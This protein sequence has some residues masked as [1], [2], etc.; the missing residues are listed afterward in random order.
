MLNYDPLGQRVIVLRPQRQIKF[1][2]GSQFHVNSDAGSELSV[3]FWPG[4][5]I[6]HG[7]MTHLHILYPWNC[8][9]RRCQNYN[10]L[11]IQQL[12]WLIIQQKFIEYWPGSVFNWGRDSKFYLTQAVPST[13]SMIEIP[14][15]IKKKIRKTE[16]DF[17]QFCTLSPHLDFPYLCLICMFIVRHQSIIMA[18]TIFCLSYWKSPELLNKQGFILCILIKCH[19]WRKKDMSDWFPSL[20]VWVLSS[21]FRILLKTDGHQPFPNWWKS[22][23]FRAEQVY[24]HK[25]A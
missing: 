1:G 21:I 6:Q 24:V 20:E 23:A 12:R 17:H 19:F 3:E 9:W 15:H 8:N 13:S 11:K 4:V 25:E 7:I 5:A 10:V 14:S 16:T 2:P 18:R 22:V